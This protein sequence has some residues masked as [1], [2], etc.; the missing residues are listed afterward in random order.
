MIIRLLS[1]LGCYVPRYLTCSL[2]KFNLS[3]TKSYVKNILRLTT[4]PV[5]RACQVKCGSWSM[6]ATLTNCIMRDSTPPHGSGFD[7]SAPVHIYSKSGSNPQAPSVHYLRC[8][9]HQL[10]LIWTIMQVP[11]PI[12]WSKTEHLCG[13]STPNYSYT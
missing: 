9:S 3:R 5:R 11:T 13:Y 12:F 10:I 7:G 6:D 1:I 4:R 8:S 2:S